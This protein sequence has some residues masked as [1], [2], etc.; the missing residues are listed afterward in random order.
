MP[1]SLSDGAVRVTIQKAIND[2]RMRAYVHTAGQ[3]SQALDNE[4]LEM[5]YTP[6]RLADRVPAERAESIILVPPQFL[7]DCEEKT[8]RELFR[9]RE[10]GFSKALAHTVGHIEL[11]E[12]CGYD[13]FG[14]DRL[15]CT[16]SETVR[17]LA[18]CGVRDIIISNELTVQR[19]N[20]LD[21]VVPIGFNAYGRLPLMLNRRC[22]INDGVPCGRLGCGKFL[23]DRKGNRVDILCSENTVELL[24]SDVMIL[25]DR[26][27]EFRADFAVL[28]FTAESDISGVVQ[29]YL[30]GAEPDTPKYTR[31][32]YYR[33]VM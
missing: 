7:A 15:N 21:R 28:R 2:M 23:T 19:I 27:G 16:N 32:L 3:L 10:A 13:I 31:G 33:G 22:P 29:N 11:L 9:L 6:V 26:L 12:R 18:C 5:I 8:E 24:N 14:G 25:S 4:A 1:R 30:N 17:I 20:K